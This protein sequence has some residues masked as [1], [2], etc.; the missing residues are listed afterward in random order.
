VARYYQLENKINAVVKYE[1]A[2]LIPLV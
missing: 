1:L 2:K